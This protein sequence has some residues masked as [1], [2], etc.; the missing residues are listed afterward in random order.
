M[1]QKQSDA[2]CCQLA[3][4]RYVTIVETSV[5]LGLPRQVAKL[6]RWW[7]GWGVASLERGPCHLGL[8][9]WVVSQMPNQVGT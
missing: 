7:E 5:D 3:E 1:P 6:V 2:V 4:Q 9:I 8:G